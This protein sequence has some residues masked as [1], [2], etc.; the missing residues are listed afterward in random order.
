[1]DGGS[2]LVRLLIYLFTYSRT[3]L[4]ALLLGDLGLDKVLKLL[5]LLLVL[6]LAVVLALVVVLDGATDGILQRDLFVRLH[7]QL[8][9]VP[10]EGLLQT[11]IAV[12]RR[13]RRGHEGVQHGRR[14]LR[15]RQREAG[16]NGERQRKIRTRCQA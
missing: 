2:V 15:R 12:H 14:L 13:S 7:L 1:M 9:H 3:H 5:E 16:V 8:P 4:D 6:G 10:H 11:W